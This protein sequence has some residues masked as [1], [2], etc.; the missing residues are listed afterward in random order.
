MGEINMG[1]QGLTDLP[2]KVKLPEPDAAGRSHIEEL[3]AKRVSIRKYAAIQG[4]VRTGHF[5]FSLGSP[6]DQFK[7]RIQDISF[8][9]R[10]LSARNPCHCWKR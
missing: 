9:R 2:M 7:G 4:I 5:P 10:A 3:I 6:G 8:C 1:K